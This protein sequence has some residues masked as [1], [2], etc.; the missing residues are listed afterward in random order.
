[1][2]WI[3]KVRF[4]VVV[5]HQ[6]SFIFKQNRGHA[7]KWEWT[8][9]SLLFERPIQTSDIYLQN[10]NVTKENKDKK[11]S[12]HIAPSI[13]ELS[14]MVAMSHMWLLKFTLTKSKWNENFSFSVMIAHVKCSVVK[15]GYLT[16]QHRERIS[17]LQKVVL[18]G[19]TII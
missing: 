10:K 1:M 11:N 16:G 3:K 9:Y 12:T 13:I 5:S 6:T 7:F 2:K 18:S 14:N 15:C 8:I 17:S 19:T 4:T